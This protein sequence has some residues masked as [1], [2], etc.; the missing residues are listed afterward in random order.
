MTNILN[1]KET[2]TTAW[3]IDTSNKRTCCVQTLNFFTTE[4][5]ERINLGE[6]SLDCAVIIYCLGFNLNYEKRPERTM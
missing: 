6:S 5:R 3:A 2:Q 1:R 4:C